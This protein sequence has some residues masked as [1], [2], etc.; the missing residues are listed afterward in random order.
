MEMEWTI[1]SNQIVVLTA[2]WGSLE[3]P[4]FLGGKPS[5]SAIDDG[6]YS[7]LFQVLYSI[8]ESIESITTVTKVQVDSSSHAWLSLLFLQD[9]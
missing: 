9:S 5:S 6:E 1:E 3:L 2:G 8:V 4:M 7:H